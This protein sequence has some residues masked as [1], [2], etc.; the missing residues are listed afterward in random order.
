MKLEKVLF[1]AL[2][3]LGFTLKPLALIPAS[4]IA[5]YIFFK[6]KQF[7]DSDFDNLSKQIKIKKKEVDSKST[8]NADMFQKL[9][10]SIVSLKMSNNIK[11]RL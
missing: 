10:D 1:L 2:A 11:S 8:E 6:E 5:A 3:I 4:I 9:K 7:N